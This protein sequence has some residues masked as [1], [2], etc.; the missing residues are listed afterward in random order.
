MTYSGLTDWQP[1]GDL[2]SLAFTYQYKRNR[3][4]GLLLSRLTNPGYGGCLSFEI[5]CDGID[6]DIKG[7]HCLDAAGF[8]EGK[9]SFDPTVSLFARGSLHES[10]PDDGKSQSPFGPV[11]GGLNAIFEQKQPQLAHEFLQMAGKP[12]PII[13]SP[14]IPGDQMHH[15]GIPHT[16]FPFGR[17]SMSPRDQALELSE[18]PSAKPC[19]LRV[20]SLG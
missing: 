15:A 19:E 13:L 5:A 9:D 4:E 18:S 10:T 6:E 7:A 11:V 2:L 12:S 20:I 14:S 16:G 8:S 17:R 1:R 3:S